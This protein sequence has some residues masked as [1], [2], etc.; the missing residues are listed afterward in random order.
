MDY[1]QNQS[2]TMIQWPFKSPDLNPIEHLCD[3]LNRRVRQR[4]PQLETFQVLQQSLQYE[5]HRISKVRI[6]C[7]DVYELSC[8][9]MVVIT[10][11]E[12]DIVLMD[13]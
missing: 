2:I 1:L 10:G 4:Q 13:A 3:E 7:G 5:W 9:S 12:F 11:T 8:K 6:P